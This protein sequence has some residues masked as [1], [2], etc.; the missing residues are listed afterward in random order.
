MHYLI[1][2]DQQLLGNVPLGGELDVVREPE[3]EDLLHVDVVL[4][5]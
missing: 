5:V 1:E 2:V 3:F 4:K